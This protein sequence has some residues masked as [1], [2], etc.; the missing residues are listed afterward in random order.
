[1]ARLSMLLFLLTIMAGN[2]SAQQNNI[3]KTWQFHSI[4]NV[5]F[6]EGQTG[7]AFQLQTIN[8]I[9]NKSWFGGV[10]LGLD[11]YRFRTVP[12]FFDLRKELGKSANKLFLYSDLGVNFSRV[13]DKEK[14]NYVVDDKF[15]N[16]LFVEAGLGY[17][18]V[19]GK[20]H[21][22]L[23]SVGYSYKKLRETYNSIQYYYPGIFRINPE[24]N[25]NNQN[26]I[27]YG[28]SR[29]S[30]KMGWQF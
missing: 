6:L 14:T 15:G 8:G 1:M 16:G 2:S 12:L 28:L 21:G 22:L 23:I 27:N 9:Q 13:T 7:S 20:N 24:Q 18:A 30:I 11:Y 17:K 5:G 25:I 29:L 4:N 19:I 3:V 10:G 26:Q